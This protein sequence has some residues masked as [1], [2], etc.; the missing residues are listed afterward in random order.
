MMGFFQNLIIAS[1]IVRFSNAAFYGNTTSNNTSSSLP[2]SSLSSST[3]HLSS[4]APSSRRSAQDS[5]SAQAYNSHAINSS[6]IV[7]V[8]HSSS[9]SLASSSR[10]GNS[11]YP[12]S[13]SVMPSNFSGSSFGPSNGYAHSTGFRFASSLSTSRSHY[14]PFNSSSARVTGTGGVPPL[15]TGHLYHG[16]GHGTGIGNSNSTASHKWSNATMTAAPPGFAVYGNSTFRTNCPHQTQYNSTDCYA[17]CTK[18]ADRCWSEWYTWSQGNNDYQAS[19]QDEHGT[20]EVPEKTLIY[21]FPVST[22]M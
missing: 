22:V 16:T 7:N 3:H 21:T 13:Y 10:F 5:A 12:A 14:A 1:F 8:L 15:G 20:V 9:S 4:I 11:T 6:S 2:L 19:M 17:T 18:L